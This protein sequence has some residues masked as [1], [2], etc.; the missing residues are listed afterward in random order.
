MTTIAE[1]A[2][3]AVAGL[4]LIPVIFNP[5]G[6]LAGALL[7]VMVLFAGYGARL[8]YSTHVARRQGERGRVKQAKDTNSERWRR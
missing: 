5:A 4:M 8:F 3:W 7:F 1:K 2:I 6:W